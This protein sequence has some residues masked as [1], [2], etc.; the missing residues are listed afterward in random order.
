MSEDLKEVLKCVAIIAL[1]WI[2]LV[3]S[4]LTGVDRACSKFEKVWDECSKEREQKL[5]QE[6][7]K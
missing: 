4:A 1:F 3:G 7:R 5:E 2:L 6:S